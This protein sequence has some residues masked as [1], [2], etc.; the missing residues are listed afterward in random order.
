MIPVYLAGS[1]ICGKEPAEIV[2]QL[3]KYLED[4]EKQKRDEK[5]SSDRS[6]EGKTVLELVCMGAVAGLPLLAEAIKWSLWINR[7]SVLEVYAE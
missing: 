3:F 5:E 1:I 6:K 7:L 4:F 2:E